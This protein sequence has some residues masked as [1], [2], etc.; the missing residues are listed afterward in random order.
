MVLINNNPG[1]CIIYEDG[2]LKGG[3]ELEPKHS[4][5]YEAGVYP[6]HMPVIVVQML[7]L[8]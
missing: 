5:L 8:A 3:K 2:A 6:V 7:I 1:K 4:T